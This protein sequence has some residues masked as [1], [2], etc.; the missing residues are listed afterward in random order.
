MREREQSQIK[1]KTIINLL[2]K[3]TSRDKFKKME[4]KYVPVS[5]ILYKVAKYFKHWKMKCIR[6]ENCFYISHFYAFKVKGERYSVA[7]RKVML[8]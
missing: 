8:N 2:K 5:S 6:K 4:L 3:K 1:M 7:K